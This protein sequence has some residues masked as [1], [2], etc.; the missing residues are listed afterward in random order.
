MGRPRDMAVCSTSW[1]AVNQSVLQ[2]LSSHHSIDLVIKVQS[3]D[4]LF[5]SLQI[6]LSHHPHS[7]G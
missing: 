7:P 3:T 1:V 4:N 2:A 5:H 6:E